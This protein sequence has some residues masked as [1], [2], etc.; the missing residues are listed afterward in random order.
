[1]AVVKSLAALLVGFVC[2]SFAQA[3]VARMEIQSRTPFA[4]G[5]SFGKVGPYE[6][7]VGR[8]HLEA[9][10]AALANARITDVKY[11][12]RNARGKVEFW[13]DFFLL[14][15]REP[16]RGNGRL[17]YDVNNR[18]NKLALWTFNGVR[19]NDPT[20]A[21][22]AGNGFLMEQGYAV[23]WCGWN[24]D[25]LPGEGRLL[26]GLPIARQGDRSITGKIHVEI[27]R[28]EQV[29][30]QP[31]HW[32]QWGASAAYPPLSLYPRAALLTMRPTRRDLPAVIGPDAWSFGRWEDERLIPDPGH[33]YVKEGL[34]PGWI[35]ELI[36][37]GR[38][39]RV[40]GLGFAAVRD[41]VA[42]FRR[43]E[44]DQQGVKN[45]LSGAIQK[46]Y[47]FG[48]SQSARFI[49]HFLFEGFNI[50]QRWQP[51]FDAALIHVPGA[52]R[53]LFNSRFGM[54]TV[55]GAAHEMF[56]AASE[57]F[58]FATTLQTDPVTG[59]RGEILARARSGGALPKIIYTQ[60]ATE[61][62]CRG[63]SLLHTD[64]EGLTDVP[65]DPQTRLYVVAGA[66]HLGGGPADRGGYQNLCN[67][68]DDRPALL[69]AMLTALDR[70][71]TDAAPP[72]AS[73]YPR[74]A[75]GTLVDLDVFQRQ[76]P[77]IPDVNLPRSLYRP[78]RLDF[79]PRWQSQGIADRVPPAV[80]PAYRT[81][82]PA[83]DAD[84]NE[85]AGVRLPDV[86]VPLA[87]YTG[88]NLRSASIGAEG[89]LAPYCGSYFPFAKT[90]SERTRSGDPRSSVRERY[91]TKDA[92]VAKVAE[93]ARRLRDERFLLPADAD[94]I[95]E[96]AK[97]R[98]F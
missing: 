47:V 94:A 72:P 38:D 32:G 22:D 13:S 89:E 64:V 46:A 69:R 82:V 54:A 20:T 25:V 90:A 67:P 11:A 60:S 85:V 41:C 91:P 23:L 31:L 28:D 16:R 95:I 8:L 3:E 65:L 58:P 24:G 2:L 78:P 37:E 4:D 75:D 55:A 10:P 98:E 86:S 57:T 36:Y 59:Q 83:V 9:D 97:S 76:F 12:P 30:S 45:P 62:W 73:R 34:R 15:P 66:Q 27:C 93:A 79:G 49:N 52:G 92:Y 51:V 39:P 84:G 17:L 7:I 80:G 14:A 6:K 70:W 48:I 43:A 50:D 21:A 74:I 81:L 40:S 96:L 71:A 19:G 35:Y 53:G 88:W 42:F 18:G 5:Q 33:L 44:A 26:C 63:G 1:M 87:T 29:R 61:Y 77:R 56:F 68:L